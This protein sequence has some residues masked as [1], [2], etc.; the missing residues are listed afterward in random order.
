MA[1]IQK[2]QES[3]VHNLDQT[4]K[5]WTQVT[6]FVANQVAERPHEGELVLRNIMT[7]HPE[8]M[9]VRIYS[10]NNK[11]ELTS[12]NIND[13]IP[14]LALNDSLWI[15]SKIDSLVQ[16]AWLW[17]DMNGKP[18]IVTR[19]QFHA[20]SLP[21][22]LVIIWDA[23][24]FQDNYS[25]V[26]LTSEY[27]VNILTS[28]RIIFQ[29]QKTVDPLKVLDPLS[30][31]S[32]ITTLREGSS[33]W[34]VVSTAFHTLDLWM[35]VGIPERVV[36]APVHEFLI[37]TTWC[38]VGCL[39]LLLILGWLLVHQIDKLLMRLTEDVKRLS[40]LDFKQE[41]HIPQIHP[42][43][44]I[45]T[46]MELMRQSLERPQRIMD[47]ERILAEWQDK[48]F[49]THTNEMVCVTDGTDVLVFQNERFKKFCDSLLPS[50]PIQTKRDVLTHPAVKIIATTQQEELVESLHIKMVQS[51]IQVRTGTET[52]S[53]FCVDELSITREGDEVGSLLI[54]HDVPQGT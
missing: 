21:F 10:P 8:I 37:F 12:N 36:L 5:A 6:R 20:S 4:M 29:N 15:R 25:R 22:V 24:V 53:S 28:A 18:V 44:E 27:S 30:Q 31:V 35:I 32:R 2:L 7:L 40:N 41:I 19:M 11:D 42:L 54:F 49:M 52:E 17:N 51:E 23:K 3:S 26:S 47:E 38:I 45:G 9:Q 39:L 48:F 33:T 34:N 16:T 14:N 13:T 1:V 50:M 43:H 46:A